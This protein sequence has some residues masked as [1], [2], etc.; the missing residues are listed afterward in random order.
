MTTHLTRRVAVAAAVG[1]LAVTA[2]LAAAPAASAHGGS[3]PSIPEAAH[4]LTKITA[5]SPSIP[6]LTATV[7][8]RGEWLQVSN[9]T[10]RTLTVLGYAREPYLQIGPTGTSQNL[11]S[12]TL[13]LNKSLFADVSQLGV[14]TLPAQWQRTS[15]THTVRWHDHRIHW[16]G[17]TRPPAV[18]AHPGRRQLIGDWT[19]RM[20]LGDQPVLISGT[21][22]WLP[23]SSGLGRFATWFFAADTL[24]FGVALVGGG[25]YTHRRRKSR[26]LALEDQDNDP[27]SA[28][29]MTRSL[30]ELRRAIEP[31]TAESVSM[32]CQLDVG[33][34]RVEGR[35]RD[36]KVDVPGSAHR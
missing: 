6:G 33:V 20:T 25:L 16:M 14:S 9:G 35:R 30:T 5:I 4:Y 17:G 29:P 15:S 27:N 13:A 3:T 34:R 32:E 21:L 26:N 10:T 12:P 11:Y 22:T 28:L 1:L 2:A 36:H 24:L 8:R 19:V 23:V 31:T 18:K 7:D